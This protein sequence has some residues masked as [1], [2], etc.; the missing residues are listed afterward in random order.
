MREEAGVM[1]RSWLI[2]SDVACDLVVDHQA[3]SARHCRLTA[4]GDGSYLLEDLNSTNGTFIDGERLSAPRPVNRG[5]RVTLGR[6]QPLPWPTDAAELSSS[7]TPLRVLRVGREPDNDFVVNVPTVSSYHARVLWRGR[8]GEAEIEDLGSSNGT[9]VGTPDRRAERAI[10]TVRDTVFLGSYPIPAARLFETLQAMPTETIPQ[11]RAV[12]EPG[13]APVSEPETFGSVF[14]EE[15]GAAWGSGWHSWIFLVLG[16]LAGWLAF[17][18]AGVDP[19]GLTGDLA[20]WSAAARGLAM[21]LARLGLAAVVLGLVVGVGS[22]TRTPPMV[23][24]RRWLARSLVS[25]AI[26]LTAV[27]L[28]WGA[29]RVVSMGAVG[30]PSALGLLWLGAGVGLALGQIV[31]LA[32]PRPALAW[33]LAVALVLPLW[34]LGGEST[35]WRRLPGW[36]KGVAGFSP[37]RWTFEGLLLIASDRF[38]IPTETGPA[39]DIAGSRGDLAEADFPVE[40]D[41]SGPS[42]VSLALGAMLLGWGAA[43]GFMATESPP[44]PPSSVESP[45]P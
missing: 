22:G 23:G 24:R 14:A 36:T 25:T 39:V 15:W 37:S 13:P 32:M 34:G 17:A 7:S 6:S 43:A 38:P 44:P 29:F 30:T 5:Q 16:V 4:L 10:L 11:G 28:E 35:V 41:R 12:G 1:A 21:A 2:G 20:G 33:A 40:T 31:A 19:R 26:V 3:V 27:L 42:A 18:S 8:A 45:W 9:A